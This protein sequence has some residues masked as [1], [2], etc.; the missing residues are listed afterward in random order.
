MNKSISSAIQN[1]LSTGR[2]NNTKNVTDQQIEQ[3]VY[4]ATQAPSAFNLQNWHFIAVTSDTAKEKLRAVAY[5]QAQITQASATFIVCGVLDGYRT[6][7]ATL[8]P[9]VKQG[10]I[11]QTI[12]DAWVKMATDSH[13]ENPQLRRD[14]AIRSASLASMALMLAAQEM[15]LSTG[16]IGGFDQ[17]ALMEE[18]G[19]DEQLLPVMLITLGKAGADNWQRKIRKPIEEVLK[20]V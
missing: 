1:R 2:Y 19:L 9:S 17:Q 18:F 15:D 7:E 12:A 20:T 6:L 11:E 10:L 3:L 14:E 8:A 13:G 16:P 5:G 4:L